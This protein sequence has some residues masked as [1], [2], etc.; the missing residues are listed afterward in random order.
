MKTGNPP[1]KQVDRSAPICGRECE[2]KAASKITG[3]PTKVTWMAVAY[4][5][6]TGTAWWTTR[7]RNR[8]AV[9]PLLSVCLCCGRHNWQTGTFPQG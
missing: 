4:R 7:R 3:L 6:G 1:P 5:T 9:P 2:R 8:L